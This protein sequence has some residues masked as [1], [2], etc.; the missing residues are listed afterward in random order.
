MLHLELG[1]EYIELEHL[2]TLGD[3]LQI[4]LRQGDCDSV[5]PT[6]PAWIAAR[7]DDVGLE[8]AIRRASLQLWRLELDQGVGRLQVVAGVADPHGALDIDA[9]HQLLCLGVA[10]VALDLAELSSVSDFH[11]LG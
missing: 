3:D 6:L 10:I 5:V 9:Q 11:D 2:L 8:L 4:G 1:V 7:V